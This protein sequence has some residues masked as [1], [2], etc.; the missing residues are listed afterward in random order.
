MDNKKEEKREDTPVTRLQDLFLQL[1]KL[2]I[3]SFQN[4]VVLLFTCFIAIVG[5]LYVIFSLLGY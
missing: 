5:F 3:G 4:I 2:F 1:T